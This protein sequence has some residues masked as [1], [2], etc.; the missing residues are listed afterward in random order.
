M[1][2][3]HWLIQVVYDPTLNLY[4]LSSLKA[5]CLTGSPIPPSVAIL[6]SKKLNIDMMIT[7]GST[8][9][10]D[11]SCVFVQEGHKSCTT[12]GKPIGNNKIRIVNKSGHPAMFGEEGEVLVKPDIAFEGYFDERN[13]NEAVT[14]DGWFR[15]GDIGKLD[16]DGYLTITG[17]TKDVIIRSCYNIYPFPLEKAL[18]SHPAVKTIQ[19][20]GIPDYRYGEDVCA[21]VILNPGCTLTVEDIEKHCVDKFIVNHLPK[22]C[23]QFDEFPKG[24]TGKIDRKKLREMAIGRITVPTSPYET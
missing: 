11:V 10:F 19:I 2:T 6:L 15:M 8:E 7:Y 21:C 16:Q 4:D 17:R 20:V 3:F 12:V 23:L 5:G 22:H 14:S 9:I 18:L 24:F 1:L 13:T